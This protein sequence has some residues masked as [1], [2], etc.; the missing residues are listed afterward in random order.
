MIWR[1]YVTV[2]LCI[3]YI[4]TDMTTIKALQLH[5]QDLIPAYELLL[6]AFKGITVL[7]YKIQIYHKPF[8]KPYFFNINCLHH[9]V[10]TAQ[11]K[12]TKSWG[13]IPI[14]KDSSLCTNVTEI[15]QQRTG[16]HRCVR[17]RSVVGQKAAWCRSRVREYFWMHR[18]YITTVA[19]VDIV[20]PDRAALLN[21]TGSEQKPAEAW[22]LLQHSVFTITSVCCR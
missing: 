8:W 15:L 20:S 17:N 14:V 18:G 7:Q 21:A 11:Q 16:L 6:Q 12:C 22:H 10:S 2:T 19:Y 5:R 4:H 9:F 1:N 3:T 13:T